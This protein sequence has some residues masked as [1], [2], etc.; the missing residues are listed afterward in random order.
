MTERPLL[1]DTHVWLWALL[2]D[3]QLKTPARRRISE[4]LRSGAVLI[5]A[6]SVWEAAM[7]WKKGRIQVLQ[8]L[9][10]WFGEA[11]DKSGFEL[12][13]LLPEVSLDAVDLPGTFHDDPADRIIIAT[14]RFNRAQLLTRDRRMLDYARSG[15]VHA[16]EA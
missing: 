16:I 7:L 13:P 8:P 15:H 14:A 3:P 5:S 2:G 4:A 6:I 1:L 12:A 10:E 9:H 11:F